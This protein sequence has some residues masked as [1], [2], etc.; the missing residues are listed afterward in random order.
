MKRGRGGREDR[1]MLNYKQEYEREE[2]DKDGKKRRR[3]ECRERRR[4]E[5][6]KERER[7]KRNEN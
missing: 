6:G 7:K 4:T 2:V 5:V 1:K 3:E